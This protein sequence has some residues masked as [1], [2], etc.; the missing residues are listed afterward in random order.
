MILSE[1][2][3]CCCRA[4]RGSLPNSVI[5]AWIPEAFRLDFHRGISPDNAARIRVTEIFGETVEVVEDL[6]VGPISRFFP[7]TSLEPNLGE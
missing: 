1:Y 2:F 6:P 3:K 7:P 5:E 4:A